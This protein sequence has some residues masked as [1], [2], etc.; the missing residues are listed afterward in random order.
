MVKSCLDFLNLCEKMIPRCTETHIAQ[1]F[2]TSRTN[3]L[4]EMIQS[5]IPE[6]L[7]KIYQEVVQQNAD[8]IELFK[9]EYRKYIEELNCVGVNFSISVEECENS[10]KIDRFFHTYI[11]KK[12]QQKQVDAILCNYGIAKALTLFHDFHR[13][14]L[15][16][17]AQEICEFLE[18]T[19]C[20]SVDREM[21]E[22][23]FQDAVEYH[24]DW[25]FNMEED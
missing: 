6:I 7:E 23:I 12:L 4:S 24:S 15:G 20:Y 3:T 21:V 13:I 18:E 2:R 5:M 17:S 9:E 1:I 22:L 8:E 14:G 16:D 10:L 19:Y 25:R 11:Y